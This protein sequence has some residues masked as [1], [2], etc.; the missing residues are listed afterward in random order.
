MTKLDAANR[1]I[2][3]QKTLLTKYKK[4]DTRFKWTTGIALCV[5]AILILAFGFATDWTAG[6]RKHNVSTLETTTNPSGTGSTQDTGGASTDQS[7]TTDTSSDTTKTADN[8]TSTSDSNTSS[9]GSTTA[10]ASN[11]NVSVGLS[12]GLASLYTGSSLGNTISS[13]LQ[14]AN[15]LGLSTSCHTEIII[16]SCSFTQSNG[17]GTVTI[18]NLLGTG[19]VTSVTEN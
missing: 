5:I 12:S 9:N 18:N 8:T 1:K 3:Q 16:Q 13:V 19:T 11:S 2:N 15:Q 7:S 6:L 10:S 14:R 4:E 17:T